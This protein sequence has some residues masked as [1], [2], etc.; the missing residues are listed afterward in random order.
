MDLSSLLN[1]PMGKT[2]I[3]SVA[4]KL[5]MDESQASSAVNAAIPAILSGI[6]KNAQTEE[7]ASSLNKALE[8]HDGGILD[9][10]M[11]MLGGNTQELEQDGSGI[12]GHVF[13]NNQSNV[14]QAVS[15]K[16][17]ISMAQVGP[18]LSILAPI[19]MGYLGKQKTQNN[20]SEGG[21][22]DLIGGLL[23]GSSSSTSSGIMDAITGMLDKDKD[24]SVV[25]DILGMFSK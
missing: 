17:G 11:G 3:S 7:G 22:G 15:Q 6:N 10:L 1:G 18:L 20:T 2:I 5:G 4:G 16:S 12:L 9:N 21:L 23:G 25:D 14:A 24:G 19:V 8:K 13:G